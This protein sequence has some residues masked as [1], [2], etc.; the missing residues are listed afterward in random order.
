MT[1]RAR[2]GVISAA[3]STQSQEV[4]EPAGPGA[5]AR[6]HGVASALLAQV[7]ALLWPDRGVAPLVRN[8]RYRLSMVIV[9]G[10][11]L[12]AAAAAGARV[13]MAPAV[14]AENAGAPPPATSGA[15]D[16]AQAD[17][18]AAPGEV[19]TDAEIAEEISR[20]TGVIQVKLVLGALV[21]TPAK[22]LALAIGL[23]L[24]GRYVG[25][26]PTWRGALAVASVGALPWAVR[27][28]IAAAAAWRQTAIL[29]DDIAGLVDRGLPLA[30]P[31]PL[32]AGVDLFTVWSVI[33]VGFGLAD[34]TGTSR[35]RGFAAVSVGFVL[36]LL[37]SMAG[38]R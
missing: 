5:G 28:C 17:P 37:V 22:I 14:R 12:L 20:R 32:L 38:A 31:H 21:G 34:A 18:A 6:L 27:S 2:C 29:P 8:G 16:K 3:I 1:A 19:K 4:L 11:A 7:A 25:A 30:I 10:T 13:D 24:L 26:R 36:I 15:G 9:V 35:V 23:L 33:L